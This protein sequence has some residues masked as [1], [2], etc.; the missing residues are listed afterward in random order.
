MSTT[1]TTLHIT[2]GTAILQGMRDAGIEGAIVPW[3]D[4]L[5]EGP[6][7]LGLNTAAMRE[8]RA[9]FLAACGWAPSRTILRMLEERDAALER[10]TQRSDPGRAEARVHV[11]EI[12]L[13]LEHDLYDQLLLLQILDRLP[14]DGSPRV[15]AVADD[16]YLGHLPVE[17]LAEIYA[18]RRDVT[19]AE[20]LA[21]RDAWTAFRSPDPRAIVDVLPRVTVLR[22][23]GNALLRHLEQFPSVENGL[24]RTEQ[25]AMEAVAS[26]VWRAGDVFLRSHVERE[27]AFFMGDSTFLVHVGA[28]MRLPR[29]LLSTPRG[30][31]RLTMDDDLALTEDGAQV[32]AGT[33]DRVRTCGIDRWLGGV[34]LSGTGAMWRWDK[35]RGQIRNL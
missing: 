35:N 26:G 7:P 9:E 16:E 15:T 20:R 14:L 28:L 31:V 12:V 17:R 18:A 24:S 34:Q 22:H 5:H 2:N 13:W 29:P 27:A 4:I 25:Q 3:D 21:A 32:L 19:S 30:A 1:T 11:D 8:R 10:A 23:L 6:V 33:L